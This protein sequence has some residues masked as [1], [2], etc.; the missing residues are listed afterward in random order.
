MYKVKDDIA[1]TK[2]EAV[3]GF[4]ATCPSKWRVGRREVQVSRQ[5]VAVL[6]AQG[7]VVA[8]AGVLHPL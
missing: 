2:P 8:R 7:A 4:Q 5:V 3:L 6:H 1:V